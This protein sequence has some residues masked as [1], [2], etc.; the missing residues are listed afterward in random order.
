MCVVCGICVYMH[1]HMW[2]VHVCAGVPA[3]MLAGQRR[4][5]ASLLYCC[6]PYSLEAGLSLILEVSLIEEANSQPAP[7]TLLSSPPPSSAGFTGMCET[8]P[9]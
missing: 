1:V 6:P 8:R 4:A 5:P 2:C 9:G 3:Y 7:E